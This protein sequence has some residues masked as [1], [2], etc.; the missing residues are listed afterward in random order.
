LQAK[1]GLVVEL[2]A[3]LQGHI[4]GQE[5]AE[6]KLMYSHQ[7]VEELRLAHVKQTQVSYNITRYCII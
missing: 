1:G 3:K 5:E 7:R 6:T 4:K 2:D